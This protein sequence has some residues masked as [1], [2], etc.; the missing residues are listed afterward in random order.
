[1][2]LVLVFYWAEC[3]GRGGGL[4]PVPG[5]PEINTCS[6]SSLYAISTNLNFDRQRDPFEF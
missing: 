6:E 2:L 3:V 4:E 5:E 1:M